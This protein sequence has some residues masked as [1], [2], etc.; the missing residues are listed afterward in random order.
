MDALSCYYE[1]NTIGDKHPNKEFVKANEI[2]NPDGELLPVKRFVEIWTNVIRKSH[3][4][5]H[6]PSDPLAESVAINNTNNTTD[7]ISSVEDDDVIAIDSG[8]E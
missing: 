1:Y 8:N 3:R 4:L 7:S 5:K 6:K 2:L